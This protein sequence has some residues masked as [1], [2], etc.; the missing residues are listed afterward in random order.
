MSIPPI[1]SGRAVFWI[2]L[3]VESSLIAVAAAA[4]WL[5][6]GDPFPFEIRFD[7]EAL[8]W[9]AAGAFPLAVAAFFV[10]SPAGLDL[11]P[12]RR[13]H[14][15]V[16]SLLGGAVREMSAAQ[17]AILALAAG[18]GEEILF[19]GVLQARIGL[20]AASVL[21]ALLHALTPGYFILAL[22]LS[23]YLGWLQQ[24]TANVAVPSVIHAIYDALALLLLRRNF[25]REMREAQADAAGTSAPE[26]FEAPDGGTP[27]PTSTADPEGGDG[28]GSGP[29]TGGDDIP[30]PPEEPGDRP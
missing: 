1:A 5:F 11:P 30:R 15:I 18:F 16:K 4:G 25:R 27:A 21:F 10:T 7:R 2:G 23:L 29:R 12:L 9:S 20:V 14:D 3:A 22:L 13:I 17:I 6:L 8:V 28:P 26:G 24:H 19:R